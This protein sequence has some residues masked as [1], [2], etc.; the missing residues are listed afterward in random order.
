MAAPT[1]P[2]RRTALALA[3]GLVLAQLAASGAASAWTPAMDD[4]VAREAIRLMPSSLRGILE[5]HLAEVT[6]G[7]RDA[8]GDESGLFHTLDP[9]QQGASAASL[10]ARQAREIE[11]MIDGH[12]P[13]AEVARAMGSLAHV[14]GD[15][16]NPLQVADDDP[17]EARYAADYVSYV[18][19]NLDR[20]PLV[21]YGWSDPH[22]GLPGRPADGDVES[23]ATAIAD[24]TRGHYPHIR[25]AYAANDPRPVAQRFDVRS[26]PFGIGSLCY[27]HTVT[28]TARIWLYI[29]GRAHGDLRGT[30][31]LARELTAGTST[32]GHP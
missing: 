12:K 24:R 9:D 18:E 14:I 13:F 16:N 28:D 8:A 7:I 6:A 11:A 21:F 2:G 27:S 20:Y 29:W 23:F 25:R 32:G 4:R 31:Y 30:P 17:A 10:A 3:A 15:L 5:T 22:L 1:A 19:S 26:L